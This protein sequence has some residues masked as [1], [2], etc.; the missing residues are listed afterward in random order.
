[1]P[2]ILGVLLFCLACLQT[3]SGEDTRTPYREG[4][5]IL[6]DGNGLWSGMFR[7]LSPREKRFSHIGIIIFE[8]GD[9]FVLHAIASEAT[10]V[11]AVRK[12]P[13]ATFIHDLR[14]WAVYR[15]KV[16]DEEAARIGSEARAL[17]GTPFDMSFNIEDNSSVY[18]TELAYLSV[19]RALRR[20]FI[21]TDTWKDQRFVYVDSCYLSPSTECIDEYSI[22]RETGATGP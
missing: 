12:E 8:D 21:H 3:L 15:I 2:R 16:S 6:R 14:D 19:N 10:L 17:I 7:N 20:E 1:M 9:P 11:G 22:A 4:D 13:L 5:L 18:C